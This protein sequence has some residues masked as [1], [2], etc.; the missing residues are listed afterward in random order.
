MV[1]SVSIVTAF[2][3]SRSL[4]QDYIQNGKSIAALFAE[5][6]ALPV[7]GGSE[8]VI[9][10][11]I[12]VILPFPGVER[13]AIYDLQ[14]NLLAQSEG[15]RAWLKTLSFDALSL[16]EPVLEHDGRDVWQFLSPVYADLG[17]PNL[18]DAEASH[19]SH[20]ATDGK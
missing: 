7:L 10:Q 2:L 14:H 15:D 4:S 5:K 9:Q 3:F 18:E 11:A 17:E 20:S 1:F 6:S 19:N 16:T 8:E 12:E 13:L